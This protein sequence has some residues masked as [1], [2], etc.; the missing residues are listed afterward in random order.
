[1]DEMTGIQKEIPVCMEYETDARDVWPA[2][3]E[4]LRDWLREKKYG[5]VVER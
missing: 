5:K 4:K 3:W 1:M 2:R